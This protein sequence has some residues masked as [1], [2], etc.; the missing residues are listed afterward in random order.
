MA[1]GKEKIKKIAKLAYEVGTPMGQLGRVAKEV[2]KVAGRVAC[3]KKGGRWVK[4]KC[5]AKGAMA[6]SEIRPNLKGPD[7]R[8]GRKKYSEPPKRSSY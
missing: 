2:K 1:N 8:T 3:Q 7:S 5:I 6:K 4:G